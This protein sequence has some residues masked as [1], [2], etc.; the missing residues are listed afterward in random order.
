MAWTKR[1]LGIL[2]MAVAAGAADQVCSVALQACPKT[3]EGTTIQVPEDAVWLDPR[4]PFCT[5]QVQVQTGGT[6]PPPSIVFII[7]NSG[8]M[9]G[10]DPNEQRFTV[11]RNLLDSMYKAAPATKVGIVVFSRRLNYD[12]RDNAFFKQADLGDPNQHDSYIPLTALNANIGGRLGIDTLKALLGFTGSGELNHAT[13]FP[14]TRVSSNSGWPAENVRDGTDITL[15]FLAAKQALIG[16]NNAK[17]NQYFIFLSDGEPTGVDVIRQG[18]MM[19]WVQGVNVPTTFTVFFTNSSTPPGNVQTM[20]T[21]IRNNGYSASNPKSN[22]WAINLQ[23]SQLLPLLSSSVLNPIFANKPATPAS[24]SLVSGATTAST[25]TL[26]SGHFVFPG[27]VPLAAGQTSVALTYNYTYVDSGITKTHTATYNVRIQRVPN[28]TPVAAQAKIECQEGDIQLVHEGKV[29]NLVTADHE[30][31]DVR[32]ILPGGETCTNC[33]VVV[34]PHANRAGKDRETVALIPAGGSTF[35]GKF[36][37]E[38]TNVGATANDGK[39]THLVADS[40]VVIWTNPANPL[41]V[42]RKAFPYSDVRTALDVRNHNTYSVTDNTTPLADR[43]SWVLVGS[44]TV[45]VQVED[46]TKTDCCKL[47]GT[48]PP[49]DSVKYVG[50]KVTAS[51]SF[52][53]DIKVYDNLGQYVNKISFSVS[54][55]EFANL[56]REGTTGS[57]RSLRVL[58]DNRTEDGAFAG[59]GAYIFKTTVTLNKIPGIATDQVV[60]TDHRLVGVVR[61]D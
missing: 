54:Q 43:K 3:L 4:L 2:S 39:L 28:A 55:A 53:V 24:A 56:P 51:R 34:E 50:I 61:G 49:E 1:F 16:D 13:T 17:D 35:G 46:G 18:T 25:T 7:D 32:L 36:S 29:L 23:A 44:S 60:R 19:D 11:T 20:N 8:S 33:T 41:H 6:M 48:L 14:A 5:E 9:N 42:I 47:V 21:N 12:H 15:G 45:K 10:N 27:K 52:S 26:G 59:T 57:N 37:R 40:I 58:W 38:A 31:L 22:T 30:N